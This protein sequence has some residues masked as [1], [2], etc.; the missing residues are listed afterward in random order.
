MT[1]ATDY[2]ALLGLPRRYA[3]DLADLERRYHA[4]SKLYHPDRHARADGATRVR[5]ALATSEL[6]QG[7]RLLRD[8]L[9]RAEHL[10]ALEGIAVAD[11]KAAGALGSPPLGSPPKDGGAE[12]PVS[13][14]GAEGP[15]RVD[16]A[17]LMEVMELREALA[18]ARAEGDEG[19]IAAL[20]ADVRGRERSAMAG[21]ASGFER[22]D[23]K[24]V[25][26]ALVALRYYRRFLDEVEAHE[27][28][29]V[30][31]T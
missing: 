10:L 1:T 28:Q 26:D 21:I 2:F 17:F 9:K 12:G 14:G 13:S 11:E 3:I 30:E 16:P 6:N 24:A 7:Y 27:D 23:L 18:E 31:H 25:A 20:A 5:N 19:R 15:R 8:P 4:A 22:D 29:Q